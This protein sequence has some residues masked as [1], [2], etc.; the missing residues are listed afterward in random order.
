MTDRAPP[1]AERW[2]RIEALLD[3]ALEEPAGQRGALLDELC[4]GDGELRRQV[5]KMLEA[6]EQ[7]TRVVSRSLVIASSSS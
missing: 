6:G 4:A 5:E 2:K 3:R 1:D 7:R